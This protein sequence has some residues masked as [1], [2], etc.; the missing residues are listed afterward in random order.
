M[1]HMGN[2]EIAAHL[3]KQRQNKM[4]L[5]LYM[6][7]KQKEQIEGMQKDSLSK[8]GIKIIAVDKDGASPFDIVEG[9]KFLK[10]GGFVSLTGDIKWYEGQR[11]ISTQF[12]GHEVCLPETPHILALLSGV[13]LFIFFS[14][15]IGKKCYHF[16]ITKPKYIEASSRSEREEIIR[17]S[18]Q[19]YAN[20][21]EQMLR[22]YPFQWYH[23]KPFLGERLR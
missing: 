7:I 8:S 18:V 14:F 1:S 12:L 2:W 22:Q 21:L 23:F 4:R 15:R 17:K 9:V 11:I 19:K 16:K 6:G 13:P 10:D 3:L 20:F 5:L